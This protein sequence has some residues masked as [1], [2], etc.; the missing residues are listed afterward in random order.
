MSGVNTERQRTFVN[1]TYTERQDQF[2]AYIHQYSILNGRAP[3]EED[4]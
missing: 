4:M 1:P 2:L 3:A